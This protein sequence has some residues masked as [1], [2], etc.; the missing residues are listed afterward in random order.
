MIPQAIVEQVPMLGFT[1]EELSVPRRNLTRF[2]ERDFNQLLY[3]GGSHPPNVDGLVWFVSEILSII[4]RDRATTR[5][6]IVGA[7]G[8]CEIARLGSNAVHIRG[9][10]YATAGVAVVPL[11]FGAGVKGK[12]IEALYNAIPVVS[13]AIGIQGISAKESIALVAEGAASFARAVIE[14]QTYRDETKARV[15]RGVSFI[16]KVYSTEAMTRAFSVFVS[17]LSN[18]VDEHGDVRCLH[19]G[20]VR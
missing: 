12:M 13:T 5:L 8:T 9:H 11:R 19:H 6:H 16:E 17:E 1:T 15:E 10:L 7:A 4:L 2:N 18:S 20:V 14:A 3:V